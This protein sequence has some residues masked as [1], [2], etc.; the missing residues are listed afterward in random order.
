MPTPVTT[1]TSLFALKRHLH[2]QRGGAHAY[3]EADLNWLL[4]WAKKTKLDEPPWFEANV[5]P[6][7]GKPAD[8][9]L[10]MRFPCDRQGLKA[11]RKY[12]GDLIRAGAVMATVRMSAYFVHPSKGF[13][14]HLLYSEDWEP[15][16]E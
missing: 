1:Y 14:E 3:D 8:L 11:A 16:E 2:F 6:E 15:K 12:V 13:G 9:N 10:Q 7:H 4:G 5:W